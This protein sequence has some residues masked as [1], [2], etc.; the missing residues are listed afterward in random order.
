WLPP[1]AVS[2]EHRLIG[3]TARDFAEHEVLPR[4]DE[5]EAKD[6]DLA[7]Q[8]VAKCG[9]LGLMATDVPEAYGGLDLDKVSSLL[10]AEG[11][12]RSASF[13]TTFGSQTGLAI[14]PLLLFGTEPQKSRYLPGPRSE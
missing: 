11:V 2:E 7:R 3:K 14:L 13:C 4:L 9:A 6:W 12:A 5:L 8:L 10:V 1:E